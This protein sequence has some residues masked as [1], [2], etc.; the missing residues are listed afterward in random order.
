[1]LLQS[2]F[3][4]QSFRSSIVIALFVL[5]STKVEE[6]LT[7]V[8]G[9]SLG[10]TENELQTPS[11]RHVEA[12]QGSGNFEMA[13]EKVPATWLV[14]KYG[15]A[16]NF[17]SPDFGVTLLSGTGGRKAG[18]PYSIAPNILRRGSLSRLELD[19]RSRRMR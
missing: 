14:S 3:T 5:C 7:P 19:D 17:V 8:A 11:S 16:G 18:D 15:S 6:I 10:V 9:E 13:Q 1:V 12:T 2:L 4:R